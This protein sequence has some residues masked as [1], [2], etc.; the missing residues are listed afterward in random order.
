MPLAPPI[1]LQHCLPLALLLFAYMHYVI[2]FLFQNVVHRAH[3]DLITQLF[4]CCVFDCYLTC[5]SS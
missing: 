4:L 3:A 5:V 2:F 1:A